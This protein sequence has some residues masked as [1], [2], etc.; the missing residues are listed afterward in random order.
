MP[1]LS[2]NDCRLFY[3][4]TGDGPPLLFLHGLGSSTRDWQAQVPHFEDRYRVIRFDLRGH[5]RSAKPPGP[6]SIPLFARDTVALL[7]HLDA[8]QAHVVGISMG[9]MVGL[10]L[11]ADTDGLIRSLTVAN[12]YVE[13]VPRTW[14]RRFQTWRRKQFIRLFGM[15]AVGW[16]LSRR[17]FPR[18][19]HDLQRT[20]FVERW[21]END[22]RAYLDAIDAI[23]GWSIRA[24]LPDVTCPTLVLTAE[25]DYTPPAHKRRYAER[26]PDARVVVIPDTH[27]ALPAEHPDAFNAA[28]NNFLND[29]G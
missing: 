7:R 4:V 25:H 14:Q 26:L 24:R 28:L 21:A 9:G 23:V 11:A 29:V 13:F 2:V 10:Q 19:E 22:K 15:R 27:H 16:V 6:Y 1:H 5:G 20:L 12:S 17:L 8:G 3:E 18:D